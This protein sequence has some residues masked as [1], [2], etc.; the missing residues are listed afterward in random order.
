[1][2][3]YNVLKSSVSLSASEVCRNQP[4]L[5]QWRDFVGKHLHSLSTNIQSLSQ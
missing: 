3:I 1:M 2:Y 4:G 5:W